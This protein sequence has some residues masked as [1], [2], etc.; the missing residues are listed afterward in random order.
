MGA[1]RIGSKLKQDFEMASVNT[2]EYE[3]RTKGH[4]HLNPLLVYG[5]FAIGYGEHFQLFANYGLNSLFEKNRGP[6]VIPFTVG[7][8]LM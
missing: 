7:I 1:Y 5:T 4:Y 3:V 8:K 2:H 6:E